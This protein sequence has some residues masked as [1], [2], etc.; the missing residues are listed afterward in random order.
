MLLPEVQ[1]FRD[2]ARIL[3]ASARYR[4]SIGEMPA[5]LRDV[6]SIM[7]IS[8]HASSEPILISGLVGLAIDGIAVGVLID[9]L[10]FVDADD[11]ALLKRNDIHNFISTPPSLAKNI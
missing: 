8:M 5:A 3:A 2:A 6:S 7:K 4:A 9:I 11:L 10:P 1:F